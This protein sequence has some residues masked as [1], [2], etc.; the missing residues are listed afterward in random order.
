MA[1]EWNGIPRKPHKLEIVGSTPT[2]ATQG[3]AENA[4]LQIECSATARGW[5]S[6]WMSARK[7]VIMMMEEPWAWLFFFCSA[8]RERALLY[9]RAAKF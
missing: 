4:P 6:P 3:E 8:P 2:S 5:Y 9:V 1:G 7:V